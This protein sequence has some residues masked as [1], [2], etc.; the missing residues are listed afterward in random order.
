MTETSSLLAAER[1]QY[2]LNAL[3]RLGRINAAEVAAALNTSNETIRKDLIVLERQGRLRRVHGGALRPEPMTFEPSVETRLDH[4][5]EKRRIAEAALRFV[6]R[7]GAVLIDAGSTTRA[8]ADAFPNHGLS[9]FTNALPTAM[10]LAANDRLTVGTFGGTVR[11]ATMAEVGATTANAIRRMHFDLALVGTNAI[12]VEHGLATPD[13]EEAAIKTEMIRSAEQV[14]LL[15]DH[16]KFTQRSLVRYA[17]VADIDV[18]IT[19]VE[20]DP[21]HRD[22]LDRAGIE[23][24]VA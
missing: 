6:P 15:A 10:A 16:S 4:L 23:V 17:E 12:S 18:L 22:E 3:E 11:A 8:V 24:E 9:V 19:G 14:V 13:A 20:L 7:S 21:V 5:D 1:H 2:L